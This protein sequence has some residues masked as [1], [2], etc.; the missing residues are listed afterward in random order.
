MHATFQFLKFFLSCAKLHMFSSFFILNCAFQMC[1]CFMIGDNHDHYNKIKISLFI[2]QQ[3][4]YKQVKSAGMI[5]M[6]A[7][8]H[9][10]CCSLI[11]VIIV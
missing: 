11:A 3:K 1:G 6:L 10:F 7:A 2:E 5:F 8:T 4:I 9:T